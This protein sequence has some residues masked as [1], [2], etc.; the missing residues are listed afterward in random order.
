[1]QGRIVE[2]LDF[3]A[4]GTKV[5]IRL[6]KRSLT[7]FAYIGNHLLEEKD[8]DTLKTRIRLV[9]RDELSATWEP[10]I[11]I[12]FK[13]QVNGIQAANFRLEFD[14]YYVAR[15]G[16]L[17]KWRMLSWAAFDEYKNDPIS[18]INNSQYWYVMTDKESIEDSY[19]ESVIDTYH[20]HNG[21]SCREDITHREGT[22]YRPYSKELWEGLHKLRDAMIEISNTV[23]KLVSTDK[24]LVFLMSGGKLLIEQR[25]VSS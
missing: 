2:T 13:G 9:L 11:A 14:R 1:M 7:F 22:F 19:K 21:D 16:D 23:S 3:P 4:Y 24:G 6:N 20:G 10:I 12:S 8:A 5:D 15:V 25:D 18:L 17:R